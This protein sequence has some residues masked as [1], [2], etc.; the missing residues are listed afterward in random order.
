MILSRGTVLPT[1]EQ[2]RVLEQL[3]GW[4]N[5]TLARPPLLPEVTIAACDRLSRRAQDG[6]FD[7]EIAGLDL[8]P[9]LKKEQVDTALA[10]LRRESLQAMVDIQLGPAPFAP[11]TVRP[12]HH[13]GAIVKQRRPL[14]VLLHIAAGNLDGLPAFTVVEGLLAGNINLLKL[15]SADHGLSIAL[16]RRLVEEEPALADYIYVF[17]TP[18]EDVAALRRL[19]DLSD[20]VVIWG[21][22]GA[23]SAVRT[24]APT[25]VKL[26][27]WGHRLGFAYVTDRGREE[28]QL[29]ALAEHIMKT[30]QLLC[31]SCQTIFLDTGDMGQLREFAGQ[32]LPLLER[33][34]R[35]WPVRD[36]GALA[37]GTLRR[38]TARLERAAG[39]GGETI[40]E[41]DGCSLTLRE[42]RELELSAQFGNPILKC[43]PRSELLPPLRRSR[44]VLQTA[45]LLCAPEERRSLTETLLRAGLVRI[46]GAGEMS[47]GTC[48]D[49]HDGEYPL[50]RY[51]RVV[52][53]DAMP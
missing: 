52:Q 2:S 31:S 27:E 39:Q 6:A 34:A 3:P 21:G 44:G 23:V 38:Y 13:S 25:G 46:T 12:P 11:V 19:A 50:Q 9:A 33:A 53:W 22:E 15:P 16:L 14:G 42:D 18:S 43:L 51:T 37:Q 1:E 47:R 10:L 30:K 8:D 29:S 5:E 4:I 24:L 36:M 45:G 17:D 20:G 41:G 35:R 7:R 32:F 40:L 49:A 26:I 28:G 48:T